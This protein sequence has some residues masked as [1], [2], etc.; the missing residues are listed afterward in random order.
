MSARRPSPELRE[1]ARAAVAAGVTARARLTPERLAV[2][3][4][5]GPVAIV[6]CRR[7]AALLH[8]DDAERHERW[9]AEVAT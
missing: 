2:Y 9:H 8:Q 3:A 6:R 4:D 5:G 1:A 7:C